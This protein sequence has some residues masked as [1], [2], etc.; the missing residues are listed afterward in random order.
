MGSGDGMLNYVE[1]LALDPSGNLYVTDF[2]NSRISKFD[3][4]LG[5]FTGWIGEIFLP[6]TGGALG[7]AGA[8][9][10]FTPGWCIG[11]EANRLVSNAN[12]GMN[13]PVSVA[14][15]SAG[16][17]YVTDQVSTWVSKYTPSG[18]FVGW[19]GQ[20]ATPPTA[21]PLGIGTCPGT[22][23][24]GFTDGWCTGGTTVYA[25]TG[26]IVSG[27]LGLP[28]GIYADA[29]NPANLYVTDY[30]NSRVMKYNSST[31]AFLGWIGNVAS[32][33]TGGGAISCAGGSAAANAFTP[34]WCT[35]GTSQSSGLAGVHGEGSLSAPLGIT[36]DGTYLYVVDPG[37]Y[38]IVKYVAATGAFVGWAGLIG[39]A[40]TTGPGGTGLCPSSIAGSFTGGWCGGGSATDGHG[41]GG[42]VFPNGIFADGAGRLLVSDSGGNVD[43]YSAAS[44]AF[45]GWI[46]GIAVSPTANVPGTGIST[47]LS[48]TG[49]TPGWCYG[50]T[51]G[52]YAAVQN[53]LLAN[54][55][56]VIADSQYVYVSDAEIGQINRFSLASGTFVSRLGG[57]KTAD[58]SWNAA[59]TPTAVASRADSEILPYNYTT[60]YLDP[61]GQNLYLTSYND[62][63]ANRYDAA[64]GGF[65]G[66][67]GVTYL[68]P[69]GG[70]PGCTSV[71]D[72]AFTSGWCAGGLPYGE[73][74]SLGGLAFPAGI[75]GDAAGISTSPPRARAP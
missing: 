26:A 38:R 2:D 17:I 72:F 49:V 58:S 34:G 44:G 52:G 14:L 53:G 64:S 4:A 21:G 54:P 71:A 68:E 24:G 63:K 40:P 31:G 73:Y 32:L 12:G 62:G 13:S 41:T 10:G 19:L 35:G 46:G 42:M 67:M 25:P 28:W 6:P 29:S 55:V 43:L 48:A 65:L 70:T 51:P 27:Q 3:S 23:V 37:N 20:V 39:T 75:S 22:A 59:P 47:C 9:S 11:G 5:T 36:G 7:C 66:W 69:T 30:L 74:P 45:V 16:N 60:L 8:A 18:Q 15:D 33:G 56:A 50:G 1:G 57:V 61:G